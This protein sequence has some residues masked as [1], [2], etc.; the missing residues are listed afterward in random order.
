[1]KTVIIP[2]QRINKIKTANVGDIIVFGTYEQDNNISNGKENIKWLVLAKENNRVLVISDK[3]LD[4][5]FCKKHLR[6]MKNEALRQ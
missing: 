3:A 4:S 1:M 2:K 6:R 5:V